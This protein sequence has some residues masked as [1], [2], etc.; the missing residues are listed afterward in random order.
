MRTALNTTFQAKPSDEPIFSLIRRRA[1][2]LGLVAAL[3]FMLIVSLAASAG[4][5]ALERWSAGRAI[6]SALNT[7]VSLAIF[8]LLLAAI[9][10]GAPRYDDLLAASSPGRIC[11]SRAVHC[12]QIADRSY[13]GRSSEFGLWRCR[14]SLIV[15]MFWVCYSTQMFLLVPN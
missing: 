3:G 6:L 13:L 8:T 1:A 10:K 4:L 12:R 9:Y 5:S 14:R 2:S 7:V 11:H 15:L